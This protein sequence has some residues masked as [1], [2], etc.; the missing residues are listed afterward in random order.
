MG[1]PGSGRRL[2]DKNLLGLTDEEKRLRANEKLRVRRLNPNDPLRER[3]MERKRKWR[4]DPANREK[5]QTYYLT[6]SGRESRKYS[7]KR[8]LKHMYGLSLDEY[9]SMLKSQN[10]KCK[11]CK[12]DSPRNS[13]KY[14]LFV[15]HDHITGKVRGLLCH[16]CNIRIAWIENIHDD[17]GEEILRRILKYLRGEE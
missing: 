3:E 15:D 10:G 16:L 9:S 14:H 4:L 11:I 1:G 7:R 2:G 5:I 17:S 13:G 8:H 12:S 6:T